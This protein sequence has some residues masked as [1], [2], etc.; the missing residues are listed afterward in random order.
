MPDLKLVVLDCDGVMF[1]SREANR[2]FYGHLREHFG[3]PPLTDEEF[4]FVHTHSAPESVPV[5]VPRGGRR[6][7][8]A[9]RRTAPRSTTPRSCGGWRWNRT[10][11]RSSPQCA[12]RF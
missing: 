8:S 7:W 6:T 4:A 2:T 5:P 1:D 10:C 3:R 12:R 9:S 11:W